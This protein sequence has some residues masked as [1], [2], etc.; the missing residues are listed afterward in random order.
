M[1][2]TSVAEASVSDVS[3]T[4]MTDTTPREPA[5]FARSR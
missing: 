2:W 3:P 5:L 4:W 1:R